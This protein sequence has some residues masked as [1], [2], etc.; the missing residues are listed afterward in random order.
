MRIAAENTF[1]TSDWSEVNAGGAVVE[2]VPHQMTAPER[3]AATE[4]NELQITFAA[5][6]GTSTG[7][8]SILS[9]VVAWKESSGSSFVNVIGD[10]DAGQP[11]NI[12][13]SVT[14]SVDVV[15]GTAYRIKIFARNAHGDGQESGELEIVAATVPSQMNAAT[16]STISANEPLKYRVII[17]APHTGG[18]GIAIDSYD[19]VF[20]ESDGSSF[21]AVAD[22]PG[23]GDLLSSGYCDV[24]LAVLTASPFDL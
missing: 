15:S 4:E 6:T 1:G 12:A 16:V 17:Q 24:S 11:A 21:S 14:I 22:C 18:D 2:T 10:T 20:R 13:T 9:Y 8:S 3:G 7:G 23:D 5:L 19:L